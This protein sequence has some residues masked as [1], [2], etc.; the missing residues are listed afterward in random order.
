[1]KFRCLTRANTFEKITA[2][3]LSENGCLEVG[4]GAESGSQK[5]LDIIN[6]K[7]TVEQIKRTINIT[8]IVEWI[9]TILI[10]L[11]ITLTAIHLISYKFFN[12][13][14]VYYKRSQY[15]EALKKF[16]DAMQILNKLNLNEE[17]ISETL[18]ENIE[19]LKKQLETES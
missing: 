16:E 10:Y 5:I 13:P 3:V 11:W 8:P 6:K 1:M 7:I 9:L 19:F 17:P 14:G 18:K 4:F 12:I 15:P 2:R